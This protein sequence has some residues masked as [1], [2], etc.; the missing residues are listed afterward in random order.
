MM[1]REL[2]VLSLGFAGLI[3]SSVAGS[4]AG[5][6]CAKRDAVVAQLSQNYGESRRSI[7]IAANNT[8]METFA[9]AKGSWTITVTM[10]DGITCLVASGQGFEALVEDLPAKGAPA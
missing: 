9:S 10:P 2:C 8:V 7:G 4:A 1:T 3:Y 5:P 6:Q